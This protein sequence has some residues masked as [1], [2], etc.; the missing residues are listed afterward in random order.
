MDEPPAAITAGLALS[1]Q[2]GGVGAD[3]P[4]CVTAKVWPAMVNVPVRELVEVFAAIE[5]ATLPDTVADA[6]ASTLIQKVL[7]VAVQL[8]QAVEVFVTMT[9]PVPPP[10]PKVA[11]VLPKVYEQGAAA[12][13]M[14]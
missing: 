13:T 11:L 14:T 5:Y 6:K 4:A 9:V 8:A 1:V 3:W 10:A 12:V 2:V 7:L